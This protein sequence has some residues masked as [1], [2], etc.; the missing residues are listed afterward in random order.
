MIAQ[1]NEKSM[2]EMFDVLRASLFTDEALSISDWQPVFE[3]MKQ[4][5][6]AALPGV[7]LKKHMK[8]DPWLA[9]CNMNMG[10]WVQL[11]HAQDQLLRLLEAHEI[12]CA[13]IK[14]A[15]AAMAYPHPSLRSMGDVDLLVKRSDFERA[16][17]LL[18]ENGYALCEEDLVSY[19]NAYVRNHIT[20]ELHKRLPVILDG[21]E[22]RIALFEK[23]IDMRE[24]HE[25]AG[26]RFPV[27][28]VML[29]G[30]VLI[31]HIDQHLRDGIGLR[32]IIDWMMYADHLSPEEW[33][34]LRPLLEDAGMEKLARTV[35][36][37][38]QRYLGL[39]KIVEEDAALPVDAL[40]AF[41]LERGNFG[42]K[43][44]FD[45]R[46]NSFALASTGKGGLYKRLRLRGLER[47]KAARKYPVLRPFAWIYQI[48][49]ILGELLR[50]KKSPRAIL[51]HVRHG[52]QQRQ[53]ID[54]LG[55]T[56]E[57][58]IDQR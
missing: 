42:Q 3:E 20:F 17:A 18:E 13:I 33:E 37:L 51:K 12:P 8:A 32:Q 55:L 43:A 41:I 58:T 35:T 46:I 4:Q 22:K 48:F 44:G 7:W 57:N 53:L 27:L 45:G 23:G 15:A 39:R 14:G 52:M 47:W 28:P 24:W 16:A 5:S 29:N 30:L 36:A 40:M 11:M 54:A 1:K 19:H 6:I 10:K 38:C 31:F 2:T 9:Y 25:T 56:M 49:W 26:Y 50:S 21:D 34:G